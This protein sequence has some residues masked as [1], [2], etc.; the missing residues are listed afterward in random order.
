MSME[1]KKYIAIIADIKNSRA[2]HDRANF[3]RD[4]IYQIS[5]LNKYFDHYIES[6]FTVTTGDECQG[7]IN[8]PNGLID[9]IT[10]LRLN[11]AVVDFRYG[12]GIGTILTNINKEISIGSDGPAY[13]M[14]REA[15]D[16]VKKLENANKSAKTDVMVFDEKHNSLMEDINLIFKNNYF[17]Y[18]NMNGHQKEI[19]NK[20]I[21]NE[22]LQIK[23]ICD[24]LNISYQAINKTLRSA[25]Y[26]YYKENNNHIK[27]L[28]ED[29]YYAD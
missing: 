3:Q 8:N 6:K 13:Y 28:M 14:A 26:Y 27:K 29:V 17:L 11:L 21:L 19:I 12:I 5:V 23:D 18:Y 4:F 10:Y 24:E 1:G 9:I 20:L 16:K 22:K 25:G 7:L 15:I 2:I